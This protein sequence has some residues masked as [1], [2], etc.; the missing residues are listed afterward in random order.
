VSDELLRAADYY[1][2]DALMPGT[3]PANRLIVALAARVRELEATLDDHLESEA[4]ETMRADR[5]EAERD[6]LRDELRGRTQNFDDACTTLAKLEA[7]RDAL[8]RDAERYR[9]LRDNTHSLSLLPVRASPNALY[10]DD[11]PATWDQV[12][13]IALGEER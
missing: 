5:A 3:H 6:A 13:D 2:N 7:E 11:S 4:A 9:W 10:N 8:R 12:I 1:R